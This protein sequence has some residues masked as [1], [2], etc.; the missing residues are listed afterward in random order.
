[1]GE[2]GP[3]VCVGFV[4]GG[5]CVCIL[6]GGGEFFFP[7]MDRICEVVGFEVSVASLSANDWVCVFVLPV[8]WV[9]CLAL[10]A[11]GSWVIPGL[12]H[13]W[14]SSWEFSIINTPWCQ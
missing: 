2:A 9:R 5:T 13:K 7:L 6:I 8:G 1:M 11:A 4:L 3:V 12:R 10:G 14:R